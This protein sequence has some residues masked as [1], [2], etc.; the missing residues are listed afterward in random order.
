MRIGIDTTFL[1]E[2]EI[3]DHP[4]HD[5]SRHFLGSSLSR[6]DTFVVTQQVLQ[7]F[8]QIVTDPKRFERPLNMMQAVE[9][10]EKWWNATEAVRI[11]PNEFTIVQFFEWMKTYRLGRRR[12]LDTMLAATFYSNQIERIVTSNSAD[13]EQFGVF[14]ILTP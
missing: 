8:M 2:V 4:G 1:V 9:M 12:I 13:F 14:Q 5:A 11:Y 3:R 6:G 7:E 10:A